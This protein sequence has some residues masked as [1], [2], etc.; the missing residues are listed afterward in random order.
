MLALDS[1][2]CKL[3]SREGR[4]WRHPVTQPAVMKCMM[5]FAA[6]VIILYYVESKLDCLCSCMH[7]RY[8]IIQWCWEMDPEK[9]PSFSTLV[10]S[11]SRTLEDKA[12]YLDI[13]AFSDHYDDSS[14]QAETT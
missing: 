14:G 13:G 6:V 5:V 3:Y 12:D 8:S 10:E 9:R 11:V 2:H 7:F 4:G 1:H